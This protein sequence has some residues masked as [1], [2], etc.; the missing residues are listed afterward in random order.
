MLCKQILQFKRKKNLYTYTS[1]TVIFAQ[2]R[3]HVKQSFIL[4]VG[5]S[6]SD[7]LIDH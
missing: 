4:N 5:C 1:E 2:T 3:L 6:F 7:E